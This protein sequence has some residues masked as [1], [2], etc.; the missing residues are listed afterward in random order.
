MPWASHQGGYPVRFSQGVPCWGG[1]PGQVPPWLTW[2]GT[3]WG[4]TLLGGCTL[5]GGYPGQVPPLAD[6]GG[7]L[8]GG[9]P[10]RGVP[11]GGVPYRGGYPGQDNIGSNCYTAG[12]MPLA[13]TQEDFLVETC[14]RSQKRL[15]YVVTGGKCFRQL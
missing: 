2:G 14:E 10:A 7:Y 8:V 12:G 6:L 4:G 1:Y 3:Q 9:Y 11:T 15:F 5:P 13:F